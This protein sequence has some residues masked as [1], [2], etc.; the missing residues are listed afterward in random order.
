VVLNHEWTR[1]RGVV[2]NHEWTRME[3][4]LEPRMDTNGGVFGTTN[5]HECGGILN[6][7]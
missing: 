5:Q 6:H 7:E 2:L 3:G 4:C 1:M